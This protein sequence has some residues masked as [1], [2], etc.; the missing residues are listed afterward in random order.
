EATAAMVGRC[1]YQ[2]ALD[3][4]E[5]LIIVCI[6][7]LSKVNLASTGYKIQKHITKALQAHSK[8]IKTAID[9]Y[10]LAA[11][12]MIPPKVNLSWEEVIEYTFLSD[13][14]LLCEEQE[15]MQGELWALPA[16]HVA[17]DQHYKLLCVDKEIIRLNI[18]IQRLV[19]Y[20]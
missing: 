16:G 3:K 10:N 19:T 7:E 17:M 18:K 11:D 1:W 13:L 8:T 4:L 14:D 20:M 2:H 12:L 5:G 15:D 6:F 9:C